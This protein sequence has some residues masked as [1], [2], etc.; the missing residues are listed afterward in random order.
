MREPARI[1]KTRRLGFDR[2]LNRW[3]TKLIVRYSI[4]WIKEGSIMS[5][6]G[7]RGLGFLCLTCI[8]DLS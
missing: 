8:L 2:N 4:T 3:D 7:G 1:P 5:I 6:T